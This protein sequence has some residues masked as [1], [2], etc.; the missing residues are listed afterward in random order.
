MQGPMFTQEYLLRGGIEV[1]LISD[2]VRIGAYYLRTPI[3]SSSRTLLGLT[4][5]FRH[6]GIVGV[7]Q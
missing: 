7:P 6:V 4:N 5:S 1:Y 2:I 3:L